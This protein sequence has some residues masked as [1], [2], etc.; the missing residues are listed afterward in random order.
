MNLKN[1]LLAGKSFGTIREDPSPYC[2][3]KEG[4][5]PT[6]GSEPR[7]RG[8]DPSDLAEPGPSD[9]R[10]AT[11][12]EIVDVKV[13]S[14]GEHLGGA[15]GPSGGGGDLFEICRKT[16]G[17]RRQLVNE[18]RPAGP[19]QKPIADP[20]LERGTTC[21]TRVSPTPSGWVA[22][23]NSWLRRLLP[24]RKRRSRG[25]IQPELGLGS[26]RVARNDLHD[27][28]LEVVP[29]PRVVDGQKKLSLFSKPRGAARNE[30]F[31][32]QQH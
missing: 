30:R 1:L 28:D 21:D 3:R 9:V 24:G 31:F 13:L 22:R 18:V 17:E 2:M 27:S 7:L 11:E 20:V 32:Q 16:D 4:L 19:V 8:K 6:F 5:L 23:F 25:P 14:G 12:R 15:V 10:T 26:I 29:A